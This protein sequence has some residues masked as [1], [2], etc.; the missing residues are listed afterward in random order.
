MSIPQS[1]IDEIKKAYEDGEIRELG[2]GEPTAFS[3]PSRF[4][5]L[6]ITPSMISEVVKNLNK[7]V[8]IL[9]M[10]WRSSNYRNAEQRR[11]KKAEELR[12]QGWTVDCYCHEVSAKT[13]FKVYGFDAHRTV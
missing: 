1:E 7:T 11:D 6:G 12:K 9:I 13:N 5:A 3:V 2:T 4:F 10:S 8:E